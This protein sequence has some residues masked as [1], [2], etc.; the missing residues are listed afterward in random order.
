MQL[1]GR[2]LL[3]NAADQALFVGREE[4][5]RKID[6]SLRTGLNCLVVGDPGS[7]K[8]SLVR[9]LMFRTQAT[10]AEP[11]RVTY[12]PG[13]RGADRGR[14]ADWPCW[15]RPGSRRRAS[16]R[17]G[18]RCDLLDVLVMRSSMSHGADRGPGSSSSRT[19][20]ATPGAE[21]FGALRDEVWQVEAQW[22]VTTSTAQAPSLL[23]P[24][25][26]V[27]F[28][29][30]IELGRAAHGAGGRAA[31]PTAGPAGIRRYQRPGR[32]G[33]TAPGRPRADCSRWPGSCPPSPLSGV[34]G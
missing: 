23:R 12:A 6:G 28:E 25:A 34:C 9:A 15:P 7:G 2:P 3:D 18:R 21:L 26:D 32:G 33:R 31:A 17:S 27:F 8:T 29:T 10:R 5:L 11:L 24:P 13:Q 4:V 16:R 30:R 20:P 1:S 19:S 22:L 14:S